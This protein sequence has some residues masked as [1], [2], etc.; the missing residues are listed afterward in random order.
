[1]LFDENPLLKPILDK[2]S[3]GLICDFDGTL[4]HIVKVPEMATMTDRNRAALM[5]L[6]PHVTLLGFLSGRGVL[7]LMER[8]QFDQAEFIG[9]HGLEQW[10]DIGIASPPEVMDYRP[11][12]DEAIRIIDALHVPGVYIEDKRATLSIHYRNAEDHTAT[13]ALLEPVL[14]DIANQ[15]NLHAFGGRMVFELRPPV[16]I[17]KGTAA[18]Y[19][20]EKHKLEA[21]I[22]IGDD[23]T[24]TD[25]MKTVRKMRETGSSYGI[26]VGVESS[27]TAA[28]VRDNADILVS[29][30]EGVEVFLEWLAATRA[31]KSRP[32]SSS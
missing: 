17:N 32:A 4:S 26:A 15:Y 29:G 18:Q 12:M 3:F 21:V 5:A 22:F 14:Q 25:A 28:A 19:W 9:N 30:V 6:R 13:M 2:T 23:V 20:V 8:T 10:T 7:D 31:E 24:D 11:A 16:G 1:M 27:T